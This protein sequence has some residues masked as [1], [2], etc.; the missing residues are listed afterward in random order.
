MVGLFI[1]LFEAAEQSRN[2]LVALLSHPHY[3]K[4]D[5]DRNYPVLDLMQLIDAH[6]VSAVTRQITREM[7]QRVMVTT[8]DTDDY[9]FE[10]LKPKHAHTILASMHD[11]KYLLLVFTYKTLTM[12]IHDSE[13]LGL[14]AMS[15]N[16]LQAAFKKLDQTK[17]KSKLMSA[18][19][20]IVEY[21]FQ[22][23]SL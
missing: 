6:Q 23:T 1:G 2:K 10:Q 5:P 8:Y 13:P 18:H 12:R 11:A 22:D 15:L 3:T 19:Q 9:I 17:T 7:M 21:E 20:L 14:S 4:K 16:H